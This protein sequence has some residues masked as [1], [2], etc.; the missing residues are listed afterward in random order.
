MYKSIRGKTILFVAILVVMAQMVFM[1]AKNASFSLAQTSDIP[2]APFGLVLDGMPTSTSI[3]LRWTDNSTTEDKF[4]IERKLTTASV[5]EFLAQVG[6]S[7]TTYTDTTVA[8]SISYDYRVQACKSGCSDYAYLTGVS[9]ASGSSPSSPSSVTASSTTGKIIVS[10]PS[11]ASA[12]K[13]SIYR[14]TDAG[15]YQIWYTNITSLYYEDI[16]PNVAAGSAYQYKIFGCASDGATCSATGTESNSVAYSGGA[17][18]CTS[19]SLTLNDG[20][21]VYNNSESVNYT[22][23]CLPGG[24]ASNV[25][26]WLQKPDGS[27]VNYNYGGGI[28]QTMGFGTSNLASG[29]HILKACFDS[30]C[31]T[32]IASQTFTITGNTATP[33][34]TPTPTYTPN[35]NST[36]P[37]LNAWIDMVPD[38]STYTYPVFINGTKNAGV[39]SNFSFPTGTLTFY[40]YKYFAS[41]VV[42]FSVNYYTSTVGN[43]SL[44]SGSEGKNW[45]GTINAANL[46]NASYK[47][48]VKGIYNGT[49]YISNHVYFAVN[50]STTATPT[51][52]V[53]PAAPIITVGIDSGPTVNGI[54][55]GTKNIWA[56]SSAPLTS[57]IFKFYNTTVSA[58]STYAVTGYPLKTTAPDSFGNYNYWL[59]ILDT[60]KL[61]DGSYKLFT[62][63]TY[64]GK[65]YENGAAFYFNINNSVSGITAAPNVSP[66]P[67][68][69]PYPASL[70]PKISLLFSP[71]PLATLNP[72][73]TPGIIFIPLECQQ[74]GY[75]TSEAC[76]KYFQT[77]R[78]CREANILDQAKCQEFMFRSAM[79][80]ICRQKGA[81]T[82]EEC[83]KIILLNSLPQACKDANIVDE[84]GCVSFLNART[85]LTAECKEAG[86]FDFSACGKYMAEKFMP[87]ECVDAGAK[88]KEDCDYIMRNKYGNIVKATAVDI[89]PVYQQLASGVSEEC[90]QKEIIDP[91][92][93]EKEMIKKYLPKDC[94][95]ANI[96]TKADC[97]K[98][99][100]EKNAPKE[101]LDAKISN[102]KECENFMFK[103]NAPQDCV[104]AGMTTQEMCNKYIFGKYAN[105]GNTPSD[106]FPIE[107]QKAGVK[108]SLEC[109]KVMKQKYLPESCKAQG[110][111]NEA[112]CSVYI[113]QK[114]MPKKC[115]AEGAT[116]DKDCNKILFKKF[117]PAEC[118]KAG[119]E[120]EKECKDYLFNLYAPKTTCQGLDD[121][122]C[123]NTIKEDHLG[124]ISAKQVEYTKIKDNITSLAGGGAVSSEDLRKKMDDSGKIIPIKDNNASL[125]I[126]KTEENLVLNEDNDLIQ[127]ASAAVMVDSDNDGLPDDMEHRIGT[128]PNNPDSDKDGFSDG[129]EV[130]AGFNPLGEGKIEKGKI[131][132]IDEAILNDQTLSH[133]KAAGTQSDKYSFDQ[134]SNVETGKGKTAGAKYV[135]AGKADNDSVVTLYIYSDLPIVVTAKTDKYGNWNY[136]FNK[137]LMDGEHEAYVV[138]NDNTGKVVTRSRVM[139]FFIK[140][141]KAVSIKD[142]ISPASVAPLKE[143]EKSMNNYIFLTAGIILAG[144]IIFIVF[145]LV[146]KKRDQLPK[147]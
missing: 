39:T 71:L 54:I 109:D 52:T 53:N 79:P 117:A 67:N 134:V 31:A 135:F 130:K 103:R 64:N 139:S 82:Q 138:L 34:P 115:Q 146:Q 15:S 116:N 23:T 142:F 47:F 46:P 3:P 108:T 97:E 5:Y 27:S 118:K 37:Y 126:V 68:T 51:P 58:L 36:V 76:Q 136:E 20:K 70:E 65:S 77:P 44:V 112:D 75:T 106:K 72:N 140:E 60:A 110:L 74:K 69:S 61:K 22:W 114:S 143:S 57:L 127:T 88:S 104:D 24:S 91:A 17:V 1:L 55:S 66:A 89:K 10:W 40:L 21:T 101:C 29:T 145:I 124:A 98:F 30:T 78:P 73:A 9:S 32:V 92:S 100:F 123:K 50:N 62:Q 2:L 81:T 26:M 83:A 87:K 18:S 49:D 132:P 42:D 131:A 113:N 99:L 56:N 16:Y 85:F 144:L 102:S 19:L 7:I 128:D 125:K 43:I 95:A 35:S 105:A 45:T 90:R 119:I 48:Y 129:D 137:S 122:Q 63:I 8:V 94:Q 41:G 120:G 111:T 96:T 141:A 147:V 33:T 14:K 4:N 107:C 86:I 80:E 13:Y 6:T 28:T 12:A 84:A 11:S 25:S 59:G 93:C 121:W 133:P 38:A